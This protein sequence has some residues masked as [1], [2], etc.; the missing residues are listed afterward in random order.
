MLTKSAS[1]SACT[2]PNCNAGSGISDHVCKACTGNTYSAG[3]TGAG[4]CSGIRR[5]YFWLI[6][7][8][9]FSSLPDLP[10]SFYGQRVAHSVRPSDLQSRKWL[11]V[12]RVHLHFLLLRTLSRQNLFCGWSW[13]RQVSPRQPLE[14]TA[15]QPAIRMPILRRLQHR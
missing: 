3:G 10:I 12:R 1:H 15:E 4:E 13:S 5:L 2:L 8:L 6:D 9:P 14:C 7:G 11:Q